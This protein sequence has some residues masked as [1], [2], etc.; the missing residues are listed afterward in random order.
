M[1]ITDTISDAPIERLIY[2]PFKAVAKSNQLLI[3]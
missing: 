3:D 1:A 2:E